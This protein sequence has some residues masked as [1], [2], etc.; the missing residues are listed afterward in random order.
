MTSESTDPYLWLE[1]VTS[2]SALDWVREHNAPTVDRLTASKRFAEIEEQTLEA[3][4]TD[5]RIPY[6]RRRGDYLYNFWRDASNTR[7]LWRRTTLDSY[8]T[9]DPEWDVLID[10]DELAKSEDENWVWKGATAVSYTHL[11]LPTKRIV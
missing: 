3:L 7:G 9:D 10:V 5:D 1:E 8:G 4:D 6:V 2:D 11:T